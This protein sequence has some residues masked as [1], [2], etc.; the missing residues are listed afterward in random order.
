MI[1]GVKQPLIEVT[2]AVTG[3]LVYALRAATPEIRPHVFAPGKYMVRVSDPETG[4]SS[5]LRDLESRDQL[6]RTI[7]VVV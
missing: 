4:K 6:Q 2:D 5:E 7:N 1:S 3:E